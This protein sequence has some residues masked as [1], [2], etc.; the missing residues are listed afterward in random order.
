MIPVG[1]KTCGITG[2]ED[3]VGL[4]ALWPGYIAFVVGVPAGPAGPASPCCPW[5][6][7]SCDAN[8]SCRKRLRIAAARVVLEIVGA[9]EELPDVCRGGVVGAGAGAGMAGEVTGANVCVG[10]CVT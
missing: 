9:G 6:P 2:G 10:A 4:A 8:S 1:M 7:R 5:G 3:G